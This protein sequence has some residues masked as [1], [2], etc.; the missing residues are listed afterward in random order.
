LLEENPKRRTAPPVEESAERRTRTQNGHAASNEEKS[1]RRFTPQLEETS[2][3]SSHN[4]TRESTRKASKTRRR[5]TPQLVEESE[6]SSHKDG[7]GESVETE[8][9]RRKFAPPSPEEEKSWTF[10]RK[11]I[12][13]RVVGQGTPKRSGSGK[14]APQ[15]IE[16]VKRRRR[17]G[18]GQASQDSDATEISPGHKILIPRYLVHELPPMPPVNTPTGHEED[19]P[20]L[21]PASRFSFTALSARQNSRQSSMRKPTLEPIS[22]VAESEESYGWPSQ[23]P[24]ASTN[25]SPYSYIES[26][27]HQQHFQE[28]QERPT[29]VRRNQKESGDEVFGGY[30]LNMAARAAELQ[31]RE[32]AADAYPNESVHPHYDHF[33]ADRESDG[34]DDNG[35]GYGMLSPQHKAEEAGLG[36]GQREAAA[37]WNA[38]EMKQAREVFEAK[39]KREQ[40]PA[41]ARTQAEPGGDGGRRSPHDPWANPYRI[42]S[43]A[44][45]DRDPELKRMRTVARPPMLGGSLVFP[46]CPSPQQTKIDPHQKF[47]TR[48]DADDVAGRR[49]SGL[50]MLPPPPPTKGAAA[51]D[52]KRLEMTR[53]PKQSVALWG[54]NCT[55][56]QAAQD[57]NRPVLRTGIMTP[58]ADPDSANPFDGYP[59]GEKGADADSPDSRCSRPGVGEG[60]SGADTQSRPG[61]PSHPPRSNASSTTRQQQQQHQL[62]AKG[63]S[64][65]G[66]VLG[67][68]QLLALESRLEEEYPDSFVTQIYNY[69]SLGYPAVATVYDEELSK[70]SKVSVREIRRDDGRGNA[71]GYLGAPEGEGMGMGGRRR[72]RRRTELEGADGD[73]DDDEEGEGRDEVCERWRAL[74]LYIREWARQQPL[75]ANGGDDGRERWGP[76]DRRGSWFA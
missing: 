22:S 73:E 72:R 15:M 24:S 46:N 36:A 19:A 40:S 67:I 45:R 8:R 58:L 41:T 32:Q 74:R 9:A 13:D 27:N 20:R 75:M 1:R 43:A 49:S 47:G 28:P 63:P 70:I 14:F 2:E 59:G 57:L 76:A 3:R 31:L 29:R 33:A 7:R 48:R 62:P 5:F 37:G 61:S 71:K 52:K 12:E 51:P 38:R 18:S 23:P 64:R 26:H 34:S 10:G 65:A 17:K 54:G 35:E 42:P 53:T 68:D 16:T 69:L 60:D 39:K 11:K 44:A 66:S 55:A 30:L 56:T 25:S 21:P 50:W 4:E 6:G